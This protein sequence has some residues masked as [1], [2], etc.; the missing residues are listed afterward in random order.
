[1]FEKSDSARSV[2]VSF[3]ICMLVFGAS[4]SS[5]DTSKK[6]GD[7]PS[8]AEVAA[9]PSP[10]SPPSPEA[11]DDAAPE[12]TPTEEPSFDKAVE[13]LQANK[14]LF[15]LH[16][17]TVA[18]P[19]NEAAQKAYERVLEH[20][21]NQEPIRNPLNEGNDFAGNADLYAFELK[22]LEPGLARA[23]WLFKIRGS[24]AEEHSLVLLGYVDESHVNHLSDVAKDR[25]QGETPGYESWHV[26]PKPA[27][28]AWQPGEA[29]VVTL[30]V[31]MAEIPYNLE[32]GF[33]TTQGKGTGYRVQ[34]GWRAPLGD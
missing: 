14:D 22:H 24:F 8:D 20:T 32:T 25:A 11:M 27:V 19:E 10:S 3:A 33:Y 28:T 6:S 30:D 31:P 7:S 2:S 21:L 18:A 34:L 9:K 1:M 4:L 13:E 17:L 12:A 5:C 16:D 15:G 29:V 26:F 23:Y